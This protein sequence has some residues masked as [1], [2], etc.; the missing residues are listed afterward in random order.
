MMLFPLKSLHRVYCAG[1][2]FNE[3]ER[4]TMSEIARQLQRSGFEPFVPHADGMEFTPVAKYLVAQ[5]YPPAAAGQL[6][7]EAIFALDTY[8]VIVGCGC[9]V[10]NMDGR[11]PDEG[12]VAELSM[13]WM[14]GKPIVLYKED[15][16]SA[17]AGRDNPLIVGQTGF[18]TVNDL[19]EIGPALRARLA[20][21]GRDPQWQMPCPPHLRQ[22]LSAGEQ[23]WKRLQAMG[24]QRPSAD[25]ADA[26]L[27]LFNNSEIGSRKSECVLPAS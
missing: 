20:E 3:A 27:E 15:V 19:E 8:Q 22:T 18:R 14:L 2:L 5:G 9:L 10:F 26:V 17:I 23:L 6:L 12:G 25:V 4:R 21:N 24:D 16:R 1:P 7:H 11:V 13:A